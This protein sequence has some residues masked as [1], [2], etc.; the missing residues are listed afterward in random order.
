MHKNTFSVRIKYHLKISVLQHCAFIYKF[1][2]LYST[3]AVGYQK[4]FLPG[5]TGKKNSFLFVQKNKRFY[6][7]NIILPFPVSTIKRLPVSLINIYGLSIKQVVSSLL[8]DPKATV[9]HQVRHQNENI[10]MS[11]LLL[12]RCVCCCCAA[13]W[14]VVCG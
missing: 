11:C 2:N 6:H 14:L 4:F 3:D 9:Q 8:D 7:S 12:L 13:C 1:F 5:N 10:Y